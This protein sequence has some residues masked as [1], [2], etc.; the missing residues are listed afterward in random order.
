M[1]TNEI[2]R[3]AEKVAG[4]ASELQEEIEIQ[5]DDPDQDVLDLLSEIAMKAD[6]LIAH[7]ECKTLYYD[8]DKN[9]QGYELD[10]VD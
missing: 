9:D 3:W 2:R 1:N 4:R 8:A 5:S 6:Q 7:C 10:D